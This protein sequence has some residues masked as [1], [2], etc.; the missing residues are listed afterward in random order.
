MRSV[1]MVVGFPDP[2]RD[3]RYYKFG[4][5]IRVRDAVV[6]LARVVLTAGGTLLVFD[7]PALTPLVTRIHSELRGELVV[8][9]DPG[10]LDGREVDAAF[11]I[12]GTDAES[13]QWAAAEAKT[14]EVYPVA[15]T[16]GLAAELFDGGEG[17]ADPAV[18]LVL[19]RKLVYVSLFET[20]LGST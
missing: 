19:K 8:L 14:E 9:H 18:R 13:T 6:D 2:K 4:D 5:M 20:L 16:G 12:S 7:H 10:E 15:S 1:L 17:P 11:L 3:P